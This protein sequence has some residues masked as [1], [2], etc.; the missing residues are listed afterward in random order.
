MADQTV[1]IVSTDERLFAAFVQ[2][3]WFEPLDED[4][5]PL[6]PPDAENMASI[7]EDFHGL[8]RCLRLHGYEV[9]ASDIGS[10]PEAT[11]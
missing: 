6:D 2:W 4:H 8:L 7:S 9:V 3:W 10:S 1:A 11:R 5:D